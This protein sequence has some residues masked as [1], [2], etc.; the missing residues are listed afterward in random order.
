MASAERGRSEERVRIAHGMHDSLGHHLSLAALQAGA[1]E[2]APG[3]DDAHRAA[4]QDLRGAIAKASDRLE[5]IIGILDAD[6]DPSP[7]SPVNE[8]IDDLIA[9]AR[10]AGMD[11]HLHT[12]GRPAALPPLI[13]RAAHRVVQ[14]ALTNAAKH[15]PGAA[16]SLDLEYRAGEI[17]IS[18]RNDRS[19]GS[20]DSTR[21]SSSGRGL[22]GLH[23]RV[24]L[25]GGTFRVGAG[26][27]GRFSVEA[28]LPMDAEP[29]GTGRSTA[30][31][32]GRFV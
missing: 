5:E 11:V 22:I 14:E 15:A 9:R 8:S 3:L 23:E 31:T 28:R 24:R 7:T 19:P 20:V 21:P 26:E 29:S 25:A 30:S 12:R 17:A 16:V 10:S 6:A 32:S 1:L 4:A 18:V 13:D 2:M 27:E